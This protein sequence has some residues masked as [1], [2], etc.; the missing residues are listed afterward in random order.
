[1][2]DSQLDIEAYAKVEEL[3]ATPAASRFFLGILG[4]RNWLAGRISHYHTIV[5]ADFMSR[6][7]DLG[8]SPEFWLTALSVLSSWPVGRYQV[9]MCDVVGYSGA[10][11][12]PRGFW[13]FGGREK[14]PST[15]CPVDSLVFV[16]GN[17]GDWYSYIHRQL[18]TARPELRLETK[19]GMAVQIL[20]H[21]RMGFEV[22]EEGGAIW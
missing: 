1:V 6:Q 3:T 7:R 19:K 4:L 13:V 22:V 5:S 20:P 17:G 16:A 14:I 10:S 9:F 21:L 18:S 8:L 12:S 11:G 2:V 15:T